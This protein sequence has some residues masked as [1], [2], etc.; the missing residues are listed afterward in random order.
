LGDIRTQVSCTFTC[1]GL[2]T[3]SLQYPGIGRPRPARNQPAHCRSRIDISLDGIPSE[4]LVLEVGYN[5]R[6]RSYFISVS[7]VVIV[8]LKPKAVP[9]PRLNRNWPWL[10][11]TLSRVE[12]S[13]RPSSVVSTM[14]S[15]GPLGS[16][17]SDQTSAAGR[18]HPDFAAW[19]REIE[20]TNGVWSAPWSTTARESPFSG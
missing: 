7:V 8:A 3:T 14:P 20:R 6:F 19:R 4:P 18:R 13:I 1:Q 16:R 11:S 17:E 15:W 5:G 10:T 9:K 2:D 12:R